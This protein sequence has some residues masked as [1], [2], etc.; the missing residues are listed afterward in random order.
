MRFY[1]QNETPGLGGEIG[2][3]MFTQRFVGKKLREGEAVLRIVKPGSVSALEDTQVN[4]ITGATLTCEA[5]NR[6]MAE[7]IGSFWR[8]RSKIG[9]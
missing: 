1:E 4:G 2:T 3:A 5:V 6:L 9:E 8:L 7:A